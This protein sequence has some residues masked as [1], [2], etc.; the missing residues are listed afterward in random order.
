[1]LGANPNHSVSPRGNDTLWCQRATCTA[2]RLILWGGAS[3]YPRNG[4]R[5]VGSLQELIHTTG[6]NES[7][8]LSAPC[9]LGRSYL[10]SVSR[11]T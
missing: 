1:M 4:Y 7:S 9:C 10:T 5:G 2:I 8:I 11:F 3:V 6:I